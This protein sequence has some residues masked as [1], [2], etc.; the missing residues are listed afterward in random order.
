MLG[1]LLLLAVSAITTGI[2]L[3]YP[4]PVWALLP[5]LGLVPTALGYA[6]FYIGV[7]H[8]TASDASV[9]GLV[10]PLTATGLAVIIF[11]EHLG[12][13]GLL[14]AALLI[15]AIVFLYR[16]GASRAG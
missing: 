3:N 15:S 14:G 1:A 5:Y 12:A 13:L 6:L 11:G 9:A 8:T 7:Q 10:E 4:W 16:N 2:S